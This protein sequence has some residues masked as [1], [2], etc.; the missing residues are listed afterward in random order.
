MRVLLACAA[1]ALLAFG[2][3]SPA[4]AQLGANC[5]IS[6]TGVAFGSYDVF[7]GTPRTSTGTIT[8]SCTVGLSI[9]IELGMGSSGTYAARTMRQ[10]SEALDY[11]L[12]R[13]SNYATVWG[14]GSGGTGVFTGTTLLAPG[15]VTVYGRLPAGQNVSAGAYSDTVVA[16]IVF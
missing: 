11:N 4:L 15:N 1:L 5:S 6:T 7:V 2:A 9:R 13:D 8:Y 14:D 3:P 12:Y 16:T 10:A